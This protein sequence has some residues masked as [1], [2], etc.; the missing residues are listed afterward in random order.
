MSAFAWFPHDLTFVRPIL[1]LRADRVG[2]ARCGVAAVL[3][4]LRRGAHGALAE[5]VR[6]ALDL[7]DVAPGDVS[8][9][10]LW[11]SRW[12][13]RLSAWLMTLALLELT[14]GP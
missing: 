8:R 12:Q 11:P 13:R 4:G 14:Y 3:A 6:R 9:R 10:R 2:K 1:N 7:I 5:L